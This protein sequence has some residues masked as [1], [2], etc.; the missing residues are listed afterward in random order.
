MINSHLTIHEAAPGLNGHEQFEAELAFK[1]SLLEAQFETTL[2]GLL[3]VDEKGNA[4]LCNKQFQLQWNIPDELLATRSDEKLLAHVLG[5][6]AAPEQ[7]LDRVHYLYAHPEEKTREEVFFK[8]GRALDRYSA[9]LMLK[10]GRNAGRLWC[11]RDITERKR[12]ELERKS[13]QQQL[14]ETARQVGMAEV[15]TSVLHNVGNVLNSVM[16][17]S[18]LISDKIRDSKLPSLARAVSLLQDH[19]GDLPAFFAN[20]PKGISLPAF[21]SALSTRLAGEQEEI[22]KELELLSASIHHIKEIVAMQQDYARVAGLL[23]SASVNDLVEDAWR[24]KEAD[25]EHHQIEVVREFGQTPQILI[26]KHKVLQILVNLV[27]NAKHA[28]LEDSSVPHKRL[29]LRTEMA[30]PDRVKISV[31][32]NGVG[33]DPDNLKR[34]FELGFT[35][36]KEGHGFGLHNGALVARQLGGSLSAHSD[37]P[38]KGAAFVLEL[39]CQPPSTSL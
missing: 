32:D 39:P 19:A 15:A 24:I 31:C 5:Q 14:L 13:L 33:I 12:A 35:T 4:I 11:F 28:L 29:V 38:G 3:V 34:I 27:R 23:D 1:N 22:L 16:I 9:P 37:G 10:S 20:D 26:D 36:R 18:S 30:G 25:L 2:D 21:F 17:S 6:L 8:D 7:F